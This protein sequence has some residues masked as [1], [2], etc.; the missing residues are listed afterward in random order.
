M[1]SR[2]K[3]FPFDL[4]L[5]DTVTPH[6]RTRNDGVHGVYRYDNPLAGG[7]WEAESNTVFWDAKCGEVLADN[8]QKCGVLN[9][10]HRC[11]WFGIPVT[12]AKAPKNCPAVVVLKQHGGATFSI[13]QSNSELTV[14]RTDAGGPGWDFSF[15]VDCCTTTPRTTMAPTAAPTS[16]AP[17][18]APIS[19]A[20]TAAPISVAPTA[21]P[22]NMAPTAAIHVPHCR[23]RDD[24]EYGVYRWTNPL[25][26]SPWSSKAATDDWDAKCGQQEEMGCEYNGNF[27]YPPP[28]YIWNHRCEWVVPPPPP[29]TPVPHCRTRD[30]G[31]YGV[32]RW[33]N[34]LAT[35][36]WNSKGATDDWDAKCG[37]QEEMGCEYNGSDPPPSYSWVHRCEWFVPPTAALISNPGRIITGRS[38]RSEIRVT[39]S[40]G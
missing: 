22:S 17:T 20:P 28:S 24:G 39:L 35:S 36:P 4:P 14:A 7:E 27:G 23:T 9:P 12:E 19:L 34:P 29:P 21:A 8:K 26:T 15:T 11:E 18:A 31:E 40:A 6:C 1:T 16:V 37:Q 25:A 5:G 32:Y 30:D 38:G 10:Y 33:T 2:T 3:T 13:F